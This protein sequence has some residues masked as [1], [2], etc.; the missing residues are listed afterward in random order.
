MPR[1]AKSLILAGHFTVKCPRESKMSGK[2]L[3]FCP[4]RLK[5]ILAYS[6]ITIVRNDCKLPEMISTFSDPGHVYDQNNLFQ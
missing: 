6:E 5:R 4:V 2:G 1:P 3:T